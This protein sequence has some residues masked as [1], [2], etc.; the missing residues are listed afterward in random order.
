MTYN[1]RDTYE[2]EEDTATL[3]QRSSFSPSEFN[4]NSV[5]NKLRFVE[6]GD[7]QSQDYHTCSSQVCCGH[8]ERK[9]MTPT[10][11][12]L[13]DCGAEWMQDFEEIA[14]AN[15]WNCQAKQDIVPIYLKDKSN[16]S[17]KTWF[18]ETQ[19]EWQDFDSFKLAFVARYG[20]DPTGQIMDGEARKEHLRVRQK[21]ILKITLISSVVM[22]LYSLMTYVAY[23]YGKRGQSD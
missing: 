16:K 20:K 15:N 2:L 1:T 19:H 14:R 5:Q 8:H 11:F 17:V 12:S 23:R 22:I 3:L 4:N 21:K 13:G 10:P 6:R 7:D 18:R 9:L